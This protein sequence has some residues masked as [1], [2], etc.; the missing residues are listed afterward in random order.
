MAFIILYNGATVKKELLFDKMQ[1]LFFS[2]E[3]KNFAKKIARR[4]NFIFQ[5]NKSV[6]LKS[7]RKRSKNKPSRE[8]K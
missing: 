6:F 2:I 5:M 4:R 1:I 3:I 7:D 8:E